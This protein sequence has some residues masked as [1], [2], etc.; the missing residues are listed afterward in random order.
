MK[1]QKPK[2]C[3]LILQVWHQEC[4]SMNQQ[5]NKMKWKDLLRHIRATQRELKNYGNKLV[6]W[7]RIDRVEWE[8]GSTPYQRID[9]FHGKQESFDNGHM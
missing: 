5:K 7:G 4:M 8:K 1:I 6:T 2:A 9:S 3:G